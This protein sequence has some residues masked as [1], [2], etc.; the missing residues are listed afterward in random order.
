M[1]SKKKQPPKGRAAQQGSFQ[2]TVA[3]LTLNKFKPYIDQQIN[4]ALTT[5]AQQQLSIADRLSA[6]EETLIELIPEV[7]SKTLTEKVATVEDLR[8]GVEKVE[9]GSCEEGDF[10]R[11]EIQTKTKEDSEF[12]GGSHLLIR[13]VGSGRTIGKE[14]ETGILG[15]SPGETK[16]IE[17]G[18]DQGMVAKVTLDRI[19]RR[20][21]TEETNE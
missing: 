7:T 21:K 14:L 13:A 6:I 5:L 11:A 12:Q 1:G 2:E 19:S 8:M 10:V 18:K 4:N 16:E 9:N 15:M 3:G 17:F 20:P